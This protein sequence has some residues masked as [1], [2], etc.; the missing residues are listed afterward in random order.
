MTND[1]VDFLAFE[2]VKHF[3]VKQF[4]ARVDSWEK[5][6]IIPERLHPMMVE[7]THGQISR[8][9]NLQ[10]FLILKYCINSKETFGTTFPFLSDEDDLAS[11][12]TE[13]PT[14]LFLHVKD[15]HAHQVERY[16]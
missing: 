6:M 9:P 1:E 5:V 13:S 12:D 15:L 7:V 11:Y 8:L 14:V 4:H 3:I 16:R 10:R 2:S